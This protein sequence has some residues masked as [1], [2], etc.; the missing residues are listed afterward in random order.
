MTQLALSYDTT[1]IAYCANPWPLVDPAPLE[2][3]IERVP[4]SALAAHL[5]GWKQLAREGWDVTVL[6]A[7]DSH[8][9]LLLASRGQP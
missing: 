9:V 4:S 2:T 6:R 7:P 1:S 5:P 8:S 3:M